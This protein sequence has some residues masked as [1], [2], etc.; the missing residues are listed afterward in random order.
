MG[1][2]T[3]QAPQ[4][5]RYRD[6]PDLAE[7]ASMSSAVLLDNIEDSFPDEELPS[8]EAEVTSCQDGHVDPG[9]DLIPDIPRPASLTAQMSWYQ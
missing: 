8:Y 6:D 7:T 2:P 5:P 1:K 3:V 4:P 9:M